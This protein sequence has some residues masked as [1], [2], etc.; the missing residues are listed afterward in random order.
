MACKNKKKIL[1]VRVI[2]FFH[3]YHLTQLCS[4]KELLKEGL[5]LLLL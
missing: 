1:T 5:L 3:V 2:G 4:D